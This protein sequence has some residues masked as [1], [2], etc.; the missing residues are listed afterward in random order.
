[1]P[2]LFAGLRPHFIVYIVTTAFLASFYLILF[3]LRF[4]HVFD[5]GTFD[6]KRLG[7]VNQLISILSQAWA[8]GTI[9]VIAFA[10]QAIASDMAICRR[11]SKPFRT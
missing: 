7:R 3:V 6:I 10:V 1:M 8:V 4:T 2:W 5:R 11:S 9:S